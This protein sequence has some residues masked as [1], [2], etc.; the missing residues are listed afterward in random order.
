MVTGVDSSETYIEAARKRRAHP[1]ILTYEIGDARQMRYPDISFDACVSVLAID[2]IPEVNA[3]AAELRRAHGREGP[4]RVRC[5]IFGVAVP[6]SALS[7]ILL[8]CLMPE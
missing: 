6:P 7:W 8:L 3:V 2:T 1:N 4:S 5:S